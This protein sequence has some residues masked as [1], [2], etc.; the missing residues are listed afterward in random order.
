VLHHFT[1][2]FNR[3]LKWA[4]D[5]HAVAG[6]PGFNWDAVV[7]RIRSWGAGATCGMALVHMRKMFPEWIPASAIS[8]LGVAAWRRLLLLPLRSS[9]PLDLFRNT[10]RRWVQLYIAA[11]LLEH[12]TRIGSW[13][14]HR[15][16]RDRRQ[17]SNPLDQGDSS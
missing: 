7:R 4:V 10:Q 15:T 3:Q 2:Y 6:L 1:H 13:L 14:S 8:K 12:P 5:L 9:H 17:G 11:V 16:L